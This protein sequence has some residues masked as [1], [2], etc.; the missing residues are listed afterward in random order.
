MALAAGLI[1]AAPAA[2]AACSVAVDPVAFGVIDS[3]RQA[4]GTGE[5]VVRCD[6]PASFEVGI[7]PGRSGGTRRMT[8]PENGRLDYHLHT[9]AGR[10]I[11]WGDGQA[12]GRAQAGASDGNQPTR[13][14]I[15]GTVPAQPG[16]PAGEYEDSLQVTLSF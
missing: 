11:P 10:S 14:T 1:L 7:S 16:V 8:G 6:A 5:V 4:T 15:Y 2:L 13:L 3:T 12:I 9:D